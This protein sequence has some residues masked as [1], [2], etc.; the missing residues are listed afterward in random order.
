M[1]SKTKQEENS[2]SEEN[3]LKT[4]VIQSTD[5]HPQTLMDV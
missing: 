1:K 3:P 5:L 2:I 4:K